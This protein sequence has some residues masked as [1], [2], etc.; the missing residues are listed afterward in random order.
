MN[1]LLA[2]IVTFMGLVTGAVAT[3]VVPGHRL[4]VDLGVWSIG[5][6][7][8]TVVRDFTISLE[9]KDAIRTISTPNGNAWCDSQRCVLHSDG[10][11]GI[12]HWPDSRRNG[13]RF[14]FPASGGCS[15]SRE[16]PLND[17]F[18]RAVE[19]DLRYSPGLPIIGGSGEVEVGSACSGR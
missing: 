8:G 15:P 17:E 9:K 14:V 10:G 11:S 3:V 4:L 12:W 1:K 5:V 13:Y 7:R 18:H 2:S 19:D 16:V 6:Y